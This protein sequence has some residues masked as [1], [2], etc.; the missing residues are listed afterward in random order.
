MKAVEASLQAPA[1]T[2]ATLASSEQPS[3]E[4]ESELV[5]ADGLEDEQEDLLESE[6]KE[7]PQGIVVSENKKE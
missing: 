7:D 1:E 5:Q 4:Q 2:D 3:T 6:V